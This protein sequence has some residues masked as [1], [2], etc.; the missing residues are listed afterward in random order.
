MVNID[1]LALQLL[2]G[3]ALGVLYLLIAS[4][5]SVIFGMTDIINFS[6]GAFYA[7]GAYFGLT[8]IDA[9]GSFWIALLIA[10][11]AMGVFGA[12]VERLTLHRLYDRDPLYHIILTFGFLLIITE[13]IQTIWG[14]DPQQ[15]VTPEIL[16]GATSLGP[17]VYP[18]YRLF[19]IGLG[20]VLAVALWALFTFTN[21]GLI[22]R[23]GAQDAGAVRLMGVDVSNYFTLVFALGSV[24]AG[25]AGV[26]AGPYLNVMPSMGDQI[27]ITAFIVVIVGGL[28]SLKGSVVAALGIGLAQTLGS[29]FVP[30]LTGFTIFLLMV[31]VLLVRPQGIFGEYNVRQE[32]TKIEFEELIRPIP[33]RDR[34]VLALLAVLALIPVGV[35]IGYSSYVL[36]LLSLTFMWGLFALSLDLVMG[37]MGLLSFGHAAFW[38]VGAYTTGLFSLHVTNSF[39]LAAAVTVLVTAVIAWIIGALSIR[40]SGVYFAMITLAFAELFHQLSLSWADLTRGS[41]GLSGLPTMELFGVGLVNLGNTRIFY[42]FALVVVVGV[43]ALS[44]RWLDSPFGR[45]VQAIRESERRLSFL[46]YD[47]DKYKRR[48]FALSGGI[49]G[50]AGSLLVTFQNFV[51]PEVLHWTVSGDVVIGMILGGMGTLF[52]PLLG[53]AIFVGLRQLLSSFTDQWRLVFGLLLVLTVMFAPRGLV[54]IQRQITTFLGSRSGPGPGPGPEPEAVE[55]DG[56]MDPAVEGE[57]E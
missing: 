12:I 22:I 17:I 37:Y 52:G 40:L 19:L 57:D 10:P 42:Y 26:L 39:V 35:G 18:T 1:L 28:G 8:V 56:G 33:L 45:V 34:R 41:D 16:I 29:V 51:S 53:G 48:T 6:H 5:L 25:V 27:I 55:P 32:A 4:G 54:S 24:L 31:G 43:Y 50:L 20:A 44:V 49:A 3:I 30:Q 13:S 46:S 9:T 15:F 23:S 21:F 38:G 11:V 14:P 47:T 2:N 36:I 7:L